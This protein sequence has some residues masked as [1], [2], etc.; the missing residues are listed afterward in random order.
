MLK[1]FPSVL[2]LLVTAVLG[3]AVRTAASAEVPTLFLIGDSTVKNGRGDGA[4][5]L[6]GWGQVLEPHFDTNRIRI[7]NRALGG[8][9]SRTYLTEG[10]WDRVLVDLKPGDFVLMQFGHNDGGQLFTGNRPRASLKGTGDA[11]R[12]GTVEPTGVHEVVHTYGWYLRR[13][14]ADTRRAG[15]TPIVLSPVPR[16]IWT[17]GAVARASDDY[18]R[19]ARESA[20]AEGVDFIDLNELVALTYEGMG[21]DTVRR[22]YFTQ[23]D[24]THTTQ[25]GAR[26]SAACVAAGLRGLVGCA[27]RLYLGAESRNRE[28]VR[29]T[30]AR[31]FDFG[32][33][34]VAPGWTAVAATIRY[35]AELG[36]GFDLGTQ[37]RRGERHTWRLP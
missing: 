8:R 33:G 15:A 11:I 25:A 6:W 5:G 16:N 31:R 17:D 21:E 30:A 1:N 3:P 19:W 20:Q 27:L 9:S 36:Y 18:G 28:R 32:P 35:T 14:I 37:G 23:Q 7:R 12:E 2:A 34:P 24:H 22:D 4:D 29:T 13:Y 10:L 26:V